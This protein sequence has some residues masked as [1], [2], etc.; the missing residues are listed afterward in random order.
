[1]VMVIDVYGLLAEDYETEIRVGRM[2]VGSPWE[3]NKIVHQ[4]NCL[5]KK[6][7]ENEQFISEYR[8]EEAGL[9]KMLILSV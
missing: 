2:Y 4:L 8:W 6:L 1:M 5:T 7:P 9:K 3:A